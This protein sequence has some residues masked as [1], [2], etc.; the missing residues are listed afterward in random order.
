[1]N[2]YKMLYCFVF[3]VMLL[4]LGNEVNAQKIRV[5]T[6][7]IHHGVDVNGKLDLGQIAE[8]IKKTKP[9]V[10]ALQ[11]VD[12]VTRRA[13]NVDQLKEL[14]VRTGM[15]YFYGKSMDYDGG[16]YGIGILSRLPI[17]G[18]FTTRLPGFPKSEPRVAV[19]AELQ[20][21]KKKRFLFTTVHLDHVKNPS[22]RIEQAKKLQEVFGSEQKPSILAGDF[23]AQPSETT[24]K[25]IV[26]SLYE[27]TD[28]SGQSLSFPSGEPRVKIDYVLVSKR[29]RWKKLQYEVIKEKLASDHRPVLSVVRLK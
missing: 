10:V 14:A 21:K 4:G 13:G 27:E 28:P 23:N 16:G 17:T 20:L 1:M 18:S 8:V 7:N 19:T 25:D 24:M 22:E 9:D 3:A 29:H 5:L 6:Y 12:S 2:V 11:E 15:Y 26:F